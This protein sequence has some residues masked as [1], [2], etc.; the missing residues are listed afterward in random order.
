MPDQVG[1]K[2]AP[3]NGWTHPAEEPVMKHTQVGQF[4]PPILK[5]NDVP[6]ATTLAELLL[7]IPVTAHYTTPVVLAHSLRGR[8]LLPV[9][10]DIAQVFDGV[11]DL[12]EDIFQY[13]FLALFHGAKETREC[14]NP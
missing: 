12:V 4:L 14:A 7:E 9:Q 6:V 13:L 11:H 1:E 5:F 8:V 2:E 10:L 3:V